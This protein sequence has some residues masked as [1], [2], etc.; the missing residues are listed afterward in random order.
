MCSEFQP[1][2]EIQFASKVDAQVDDKMGV[3]SVVY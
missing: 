1:S 2:R 3:L